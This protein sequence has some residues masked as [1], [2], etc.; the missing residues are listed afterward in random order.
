MAA[1]TRGC[2]SNLPAT[3]L[4]RPVE[5]RPHADVGV[6]LHARVPLVHCAGVAQQV[7]LEK[8]AHP[9]GDSRLFVGPLLLPDHVVALLRRPPFGLGCPHR[10]PDA[11]R[12]SRDHDQG[13]RRRRRQP[14]LVAPHELPQPIPRRR[15]PGRHR[16]VVE[17]VPNVHDQRVGGRIAAVTVLLQALHRDP[18]QLP[19]HGSGQLPRLQTSVCRD[20]RQPRGAA[21]PAAR[22]GRL[23]FADDVAGFHPAPSRAAACGRAAR[24]R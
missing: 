20:A 2:L 9:L 11:D 16:L 17:I 22:P 12:R 19:A 4:R 23:L 24:C 13:Q 10:L 3:R 6:G 18:V 21:Q 5:Q 15:R 8:I 7:L 1:S 14:A